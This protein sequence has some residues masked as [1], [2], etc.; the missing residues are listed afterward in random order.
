MHECMN[1]KVAKKGEHHTRYIMSISHANLDFFNFFHSSP[2]FVKFFTPLFILTEVIETDA[3][4]NL[5]FYIRNCWYLYVEMGIQQKWFLEMRILYIVFPEFWW[6]K[7]QWS[8]IF[9]SLKRNKSVK[10][11]ILNE[12]V[13]INLASKMAI[14]NVTNIE[15]DGFSVGCFASLYRCWWRLIVE[16][17][18][19]ARYTKM[20]HVIIVDD[21]RMRKKK[22]KYWNVLK[23]I[24]MCYVCII[25]AV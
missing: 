20:I 13:K 12:M 25:Y 2:R 7:N 19:F 21:Q 14:N 3:H 18:A 24:D 8:T 1:D 6:D 17:D 10:Q 22:W 9:S 23:I 15:S 11:R 5:V 16:T 4:L